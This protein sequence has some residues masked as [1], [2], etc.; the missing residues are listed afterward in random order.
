MRICLPPY[1]LFYD[2]LPLTR[3]HDTGVPEII[4]QVGAITRLL[5]QLPPSEAD[6]AL[7]FPLCF[8]GCA[9]DDRAQR[10]WL[11][12]RLEGHKES[13]GN[14]YQIRNV[15]DRVWAQRDAGGGAVDW[16]DVMRDQGWNLLLV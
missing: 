4:E 1:I 15:L 3:W 13:V 8:T 5:S 10:A 7:V 6:R 11:R 9:T 2:N 16:R 14:V 12:G